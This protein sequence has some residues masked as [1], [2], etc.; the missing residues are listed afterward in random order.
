MGADPL[1]R[2]VRT[3]LTPYGGRVPKSKTARVCCDAASLSPTCLGLQ[4]GAYKH[5]TSQ[6]TPRNTHTHTRTKT[7]THPGIVRSGIVMA[8][9]DVCGS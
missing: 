3:R 5:Q 7:H 9:L 2:P 8:H 6:G 1:T 4:P